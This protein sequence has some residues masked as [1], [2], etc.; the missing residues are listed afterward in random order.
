MALAWHGGHGLL[1]ASSDSCRTLL[2]AGQA[3]T[4]TASVL[5]R[6]RTQLPLLED[7]ATVGASEARLWAADTFDAAGGNMELTACRQTSQLR[8]PL[9]YL[10][11]FFTSVLNVREAYRRHSQSSSLPSHRRSSRASTL[12][13]MSRSLVGDTFRTSLGTRSKAGHGPF[14][15]IR[16]EALLF[17]VHREK[18]T[19]FVI[20][21]WANNQTA[22]HHPVDR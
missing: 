2:V 6:S 21:T 4:L 7:R 8:T 14:H 10:S 11:S 12:S 17:I 5:A 18:A 19:P 22:G 15:C 9:V 1:C 3:R 20:P 16:V 13:A